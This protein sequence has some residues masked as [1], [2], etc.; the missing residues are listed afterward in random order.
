MKKVL[1]FA[2]TT[3]LLFTLL[4]TG[5]AIAL[6]KPLETK[7]AKIAE[8]TGTYTLILYG[9]RHGNDVETVAILD[10]EGDKYTFEPNAPVFDYKAI[11][12]LSAKE[13]LD[14]AQRFVR[15]HSSFWYARLSK[16]L[17]NEGNSI[18]YEVRPYYY[19]TTFGTTN[20]LDV[21]YFIRDGKVI[22]YIKLKPEIERMLFSGG[23]SKDKD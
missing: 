4:I 15:F 11:M 5:E 14:E 3:L 7:D 12:G 21:D 9:G 17:D 18:G 22:V 23:D 1:C 10:K 19:P 13:A 6:S 8:V 16:I 2:F 20:V